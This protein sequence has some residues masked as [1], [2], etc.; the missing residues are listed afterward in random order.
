MK[1]PLT[2]VSLTKALGSNDTKM[3]IMYEVGDRDTLLDP[4]SLV[5]QLLEIGIEIS[6]NPT[7]SPL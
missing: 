3:S 4:L 7:P 1:A 2:F 6:Q 5:F